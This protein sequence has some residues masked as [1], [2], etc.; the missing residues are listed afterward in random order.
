M[1]EVGLMG[2]ASL[3]SLGERNEVYS[4]FSELFACRLDDKEVFAIK[5]LYKG[6]LDY[7]GSIIVID[8]LK[9]IDSENFIISHNNILNNLI[10]ILHR[11]SEQLLFF[12]KE[13]N[14]NGVIRMIIFNIPYCAIDQMQPLEFYDSLTDED[15][16]FWMRDVSDFIQ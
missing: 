6:Y 15:E 11:L 5:K 7:D 8:V 16:P 2:V 12:S 3:I 4:F 14:E 10:K 13:N 1:I 9:K